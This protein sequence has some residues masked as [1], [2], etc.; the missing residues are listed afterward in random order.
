MT[1]QKWLAW[2]DEGRITGH[3]TVFRLVQAA[4]D[5]DPTSF[6][7]LVPADTLTELRAKTVYIPTPDEFRIVRSV[8]R[9]G[10]FDA[11]EEAAKKLTEKERF[12]AGLRAWKAYFDAQQAQG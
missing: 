1:P 8:C 9:I 2:Y 12:V 6:A 7:E 10:P 5:H 4:T 3:E 11:A